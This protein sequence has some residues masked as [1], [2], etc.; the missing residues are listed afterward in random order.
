MGGQQRT[1]P[2]RLDGVRDA[3]SRQF[4]MDEPPE[5]PHQLCVVQSPVAHFCLQRVVLDQCVEVVVRLLGIELARQHQRAKNVGLKLD[6][7][8]AE[9]GF[10][11]SIVEA[12]VVGDQEPAVETAGEGSAIIERSFDTVQMDRDL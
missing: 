12:R 4:P 9:L 6:A 10:Q 7:G 1:R 5:L 11:E 8:P 2:Q 3:R